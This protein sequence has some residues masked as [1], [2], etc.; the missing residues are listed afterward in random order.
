MSHTV[1][2]RPPSFSAGVRA[3][4]PLSLAFTV[5]FRRLPSLPFLLL[6]LLLLLLSTAA[7]VAVAQCA[8]IEDIQNYRDA[9]ATTTELDLRYVVVILIRSHT[10]SSL[11]PLSLLSLLSY[12]LTHVAL[13]FLFLLL[14]LL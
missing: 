7:D 2:Q 14:H 11:S 10:L 5:S 8:D 6:S 4:P 12:I 9:T 13:L 1:Q 3:P